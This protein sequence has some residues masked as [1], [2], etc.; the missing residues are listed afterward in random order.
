[1]KI[2]KPMF[3]NK[4]TCFC[5]KTTVILVTKTNFISDLQKIYASPHMDPDL[6]PR[7]LQNKVMFDIRYYFCRRGGENIEDMTKS[8]FQ[9]HYDV[10]TKITYV[11]KVKD[12]MT[13]N[14]KENDNEIVTGFMPQLLG[15]DG[16]PHKMCPVRTFENYI[17]YLHPDLDLLWQHPKEKIP[18]GNKNP[19]IWY[20]KRA[21]GHNPIDSFMSDLSN[22]CDLSQRYTNHCI[23]VTGATRLGQRFTNKQVMSVTGH[24]SMESLA[25]YQ[26]VAADEKLMMGMWLTYNLLHPDEAFA[27]RAKN[28]PQQQEIP[29]LPALPSSSTSNLHNMQIVP[30]NQPPNPV[31][32]QPMQIEVG[33]DATPQPSTPKDP[34][35]PDFDLQALLQEFN[36]DDQEN[37]LVVAAQQVEDQY[38]VQ[39]TAMVTKIASPRRN[40]VPSF[41][42]C[43]IGTI[44]INIYKQ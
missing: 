9:L 2:K 39:R 36:T 1:M 30:V 37:Q 31:P 43:K 11:K 8:T 22:L 38:M 19:Y 15:P 18:T 27:L 7:Q 29:P 10:E 25:I 5:A 40:Q 23:R 6:G 20:D 16:N 14:H 21:V 35:S 24:K 4:A 28:E 13:K 33:M 17:G 34:P 26:R 41:A 12:E 3:V 32:N 44:N 42:N